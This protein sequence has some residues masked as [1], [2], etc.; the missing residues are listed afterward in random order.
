MEVEQHMGCFCESKETSIVDKPPKHDVAAAV[1][2]RQEM[3]VVLKVP[4][5]SCCLCHLTL[6]AA[7]TQC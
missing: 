4:C 2:V 6:L 5:Y 7:L 1:F 3:T